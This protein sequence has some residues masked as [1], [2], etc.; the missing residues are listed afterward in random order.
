MNGHIFF[1]T[2]LSLQSFYLFIDFFCQS[3]YIML[4]DS[5]ACFHVKSLWQQPKQDR[6]FFICLQLIIDLQQSTENKYWSKATVIWKHIPRK[7]RKNENKYPEKKNKTHARMCSDF[8]IQKSMQNTILVKH[9]M[10]KDIK[11]DITPRK[12]TCPV[13]GYN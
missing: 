6:S 9:N 10:T 11:E 7:K 1:I 13:C 5:K 3:L 8:T 4:L 2:D 12:D